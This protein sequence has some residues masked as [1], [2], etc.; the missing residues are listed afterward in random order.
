MESVVTEVPT[1]CGRCGQALTLRCEGRELCE[2]CR[3]GRTPTA[4]QAEDS[5]AGATEPEIIRPP[6]RGCG[7]VKAD[8][9]YIV[10]VAIDG[11]CLS[12]R[13]QGLHLGAN[14]DADR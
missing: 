11:Y 7:R 5:A 8:A 2:R 9:G 1:H 14:S 3:L 10:A 13:V 12:C 6:C 4:E